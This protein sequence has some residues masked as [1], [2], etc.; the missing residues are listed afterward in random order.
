MRGMWTM[1]V[2]MFRDSG[3][4]IGF[5]LVEVRVGL[6]EGRFGE[7]VG[8]GS[9]SCEGGSRDAAENGVELSQVRAKAISQWKKMDNLRFHFRGFVIVWLGYKCYA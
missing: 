8:R 9:G 2:P 7:A 3:K 6:V 5:I 1:S 4:G